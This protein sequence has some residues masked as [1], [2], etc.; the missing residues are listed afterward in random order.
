MSETRTVS[1]EE[2]PVARVYADA[3]WEVAVRDGV[4]EDFIE[5]YDSLVADVLDKQSE[6]E[7]FFSLGSIN[8]DQRQAMVDHIFKDRA[9][10]LLYNFL[11]T[12]NAH[13]RLGLI[14]AVGVCLKERYDQSK[15]LVPVL[16]KTAV[17]LQEDQRQAVLKLL[18]DDFKIKP[19]LESET[20]PS[21]LGGIWL[22]VGDQ[23]Y[24]RSVRFNLKQLRG[25]ILTRSSHEIQSGRNI[26]DRSTGD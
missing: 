19:H 5:E 26:V 6:L 25:K 11:K 7:I 8:P 3:V 1:V 14:R 24:D 16:I 13:D 21:L 20:D 23:V 22:K 4:V 18:T 2:L 10:D 15:G 12:L 17:P 9:S